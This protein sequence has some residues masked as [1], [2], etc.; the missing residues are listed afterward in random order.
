MSHQKH[1]HAAA[2]GRD[3]QPAANFVRQFFAGEGMLP[4]V[5]RATGVMHNQ[6]QI[7]HERVFHFVENFLLRGQLGIGG[8]AQLIKLLD[9]LQRVFISRE[10]VKELMLLQ[11][12]QAA[13]LG[14]ITPQK[15]DAMHLPQGASHIA[16]PT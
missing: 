15:A 10:L 16:P 2:R 4:H 1:Q 5:F 7:K 13:E 12:R 14:Q 3:L 9:R 8:V 6:R 11:V